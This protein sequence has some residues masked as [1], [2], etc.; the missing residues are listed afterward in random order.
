MGLKGIKIRGGWCFRDVLTSLQTG[1]IRGTLLAIEHMRKD[2]GGV[3]G[4]IV[5]ISSYGGILFLTQDGNQ[6]CV[7]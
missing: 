5:N 1:T 6:G 3:G 7:Q 4:I 2:K